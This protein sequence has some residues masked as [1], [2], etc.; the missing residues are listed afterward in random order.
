[1]FFALSMILS[2]G[3][4]VNKIISQKTNKNNEKTKN[5]FDS[6]KRRGHGQ[7]K[8]DPKRHK[9]PE[10]SNR[11]RTPGHLHGGLSHYKEVINM[12]REEIIE[13]INDKLREADD[14]TLDE[15]YWTLEIGL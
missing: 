7:G 15:I 13:R 1:M 2:G 4:N 10:Q 12:E 14:D 3:C 9:I 11:R 6:Q 5:F 8:G